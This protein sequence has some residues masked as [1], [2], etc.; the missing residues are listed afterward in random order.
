MRRFFLIIL[1]IFVNIF[2]LTHA[3]IPHHHHNNIPHIIWSAD[4][5]AHPASDSQENSCCCHH[6]EETTESCSLDQDVDVV[7]EIKN[8]ASFDSLFQD[9]FNLLSYAILFSIHGKLSFPENFPP[10]YTIVYLNYHFDA[11]CQGFGLRAPPF[12]CA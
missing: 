11:A 12:L 6:E 3:V 1:T 10:E 5:E 2:L 7:I 4:P 8:S 9:Y